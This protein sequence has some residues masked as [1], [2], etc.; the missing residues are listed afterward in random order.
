MVEIPVD[1]KKSHFLDFTCMFTEPN[2]SMV[3]YRK[4]TFED[5]DNI[6]Q[7]HNNFSQ[8]NPRKTDCT[9]PIGGMGRAETHCPKTHIKITS[10]E[11]VSDK[12]YKG[13]REVV[14]SPKL[15]L[16][17]TLILKYFW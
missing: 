1:E 8:C 3:Q 15:T 16:M 9:E 13:C 11:E 5:A 6:V 17:A 4:C 12:P 2:E 14:T 10:P 7:A